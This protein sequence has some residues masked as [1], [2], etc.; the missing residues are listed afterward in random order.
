MPIV[1]QQWLATAPVV[2]RPQG[3]R[4]LTTVERAAAWLAPD[5]GTLA[6]QNTDMIARLILAVSGLVMSHLNRD[7]LARTLRTETHPSSRTGRIVLRHWPALSLG[8]VLLGAATSPALG[9]TLEQIGGGAQRVIASASQN[10]S[11][12]GGPDGVTIS[13]VSGFVRSEAATVPSSGVLGVV[14]SSVLLYNEGVLDTEGQ[15]VPE[16]LYSVTAAGA[17]LFDASLAGESVEI[18]YSYV[19]EDIEQVVIEEVGLAFRSRSRIGE[20]SKALPNGGG[21]S[22][23]LPRALS[24]LSRDALNNYRRVV[25][26]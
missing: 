6:A 19:P 3:I 13:Y 24:Q 9:I 12:V 21:T 1:L 22:S 7:T 8:S 25:P 14:P 4:P 10:A 15:T 11:L 5:Q 20:A 17:Y 26:S 16:S 2:T 23:Y 18:V